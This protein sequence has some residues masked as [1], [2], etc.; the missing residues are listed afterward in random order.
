MEVTSVHVE[1]YNIQ[2][3]RT[4]SFPKVTEYVI[5]GSRTGTLLL[6]IQSPSCGPSSRPDT[7]VELLELGTLRMNE[8]RS[9]Y[10]P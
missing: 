6:L 4:E 10:M 7:P 5:R 1:L 3:A 2:N 9:I 8:T